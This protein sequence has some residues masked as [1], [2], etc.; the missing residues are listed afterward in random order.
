MP[1]SVR[2]L[3][4]AKAV[5]C[6]QIASLTVKGLTFYLAILSDKITRALPTSCL[7]HQRREAPH[8]KVLDEITSDLDQERAAWALGAT[9]PGLCKALRTVWLSMGCP[10]PFCVCVWWVCIFCSKP[11]ILLVWLSC[12]MDSRACSLCSCISWNCMATGPWHCLGGL[13]ASVATPVALACLLA[14]FHPWISLSKQGRCSGC[15]WAFTVCCGGCI[16]LIH[17]CGFLLQPPLGPVTMIRSWCL[18]CWI[19]WAMRGR[20]SYRRSGGAE[21]S[22]P[23]IHCFAPAVRSGDTFHCIFSPHSWIA[24]LVVPLGNGWTWSGREL[25]FSWSISCDACATFPDCI[26]C[27]FVDSQPMSFANPNQ[28]CNAS[29]PCCDGVQRFRWSIGPQQSI[30]VRWLPGVIFEVRLDLCMKLHTRRHMWRNCC[31]AIT[32]DGA[33]WSANHA[34]KALHC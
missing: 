8:G 19:C 18:S 1:P 12:V 13:L 15:C 33:L 32:T 5:C 4:F 26:K 16:L 23:M 28:P 14:L 21:L 30:N 9:Q 11:S 20:P 2:L 6:H 17:C 10:M 31:V 24:S 25:R 29:K 27:C 22:A 7:G 3:H 34:S